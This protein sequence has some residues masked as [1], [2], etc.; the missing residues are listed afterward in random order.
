MYVQRKPR[1]WW[2]YFNVMYKKKKKDKKK[3]RKITETKYACEEKVTKH[4]IV[5]V[6]VRLST[7]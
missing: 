2:L 4:Y 7:Q 6:L 1:D 3:R 5:F